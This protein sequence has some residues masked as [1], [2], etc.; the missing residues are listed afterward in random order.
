MSYSR[1]VAYIP[2][3]RIQIGGTYGT[4]EEWSTGW[5]VQSLDANGRAIT[6]PAVLQQQ[7]E[8]GISNVVNA[9]R[10]FHVKD[11]VAPSNCVLDRVSITV[12]GA[13]GKKAPGTDSTIVMAPENGLPT[14]GTA[15]PSYPPQIACAYSTVTAK[16]R[17]RGSKGRWFYPTT[18]QI[19]MSTF[20]MPAQVQGALLAA[21]AT[22]LNQINDTNAGV[23][24]SWQVIIASSLAGTNTPVTAVRVGRALDTIRRRRN[25]VNEAYNTQALT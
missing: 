25:H 18:P 7:A 1:R 21:G 9:C 12:I 15:T 19:D 3:L 16:P 8:L 11:Y 4:V 22:L 23:D 2:H 17:G 5:R 10:V 6:A 24:V 14:A 13:D 20:Q